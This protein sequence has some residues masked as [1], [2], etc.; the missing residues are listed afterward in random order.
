MKARTLVLAMCCLS[1]LAVACKEEDELPE[2]DC[3]TGEIPVYSEVAIFDK[4]AT[5]HAESLTGTQRRSAPMTINFDTYEG[6]E[7]YA[8]KAAEEVNEGEMPPSG[9][10]VTVTEEEK[11]EMYRWALCGAME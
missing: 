7:P 1:T 5:C 8:T 3:S 2:V 11:Q 10:G 6:A 9:S 4:C